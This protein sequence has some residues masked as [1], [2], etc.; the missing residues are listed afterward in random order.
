MSLVDKI[1]WYWRY[2]TKLSVVH[3][4]LLCL[5]VLMEITSNHNKQD[6]STTETGRIWVLLLKCYWETGLVHS[7]FVN[8]ARNRKCFRCQEP[9]PKR[10]KS[11]RVGVPL[12]LLLELQEKQG[13][14]EVQL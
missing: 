14:Q 8:F 6:N 1:S 11:R 5:F 12:M 9:Q 4:L 10:V 7:V 2:S 13:V 3:C